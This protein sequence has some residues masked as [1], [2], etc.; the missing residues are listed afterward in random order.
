MLSDND[1]E[2]LSV[3][4]D[5]ALSESERNALEV[6]L[7][8]D[9]ELRREL[10]RLRATVELV[11]AL[12]TLAAPRDF[13]LTPRMVRR[14]PTILTSAAFSAL[15]AAA[16]VVLLIVGV[17]L[18]NTSMRVPAGSLTANQV[19]LAPTVLAATTQDDVDEAAREQAAGGGALAVSSPQPTQERL[20]DILPA[21]T[22]TEMGTES[23]FYTAP[24]NATLAEEADNFAGAA[25]DAA[26]SQQQESEGS[27]ALQAAAPTETM[28]ILRMAEPSQPPASAASGVAEVR[29]P[30][31]GEAPIV[32]Q[33]SSETA[34]SAF[35]ATS[36]MTPTETPMPVPSP[37]PTAV[38]S[39]VFN[40][41]DST[42]IG[43]GLIILALVL[44]LAAGVTTILRRRA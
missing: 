15:S 18:F 39:S 34:V 40:S 29:P 27:S 38:P 43:A 2:L 8:D 7:A 9:A 24:E 23:Q 31:P 10:Q 35:S 19:A 36:T 32:A 20:R 13:T 26:L 3:Y 22:E 6:R 30:A 25:A 1:L 5:G 17:A 44:L 11:N 42:G 12:P 14:S 16:A 28:Q 41:S 4:I 37:T 33:A 21:P